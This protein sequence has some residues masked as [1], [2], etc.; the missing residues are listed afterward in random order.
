MLYASD[1]FVNRGEL[2]VI[3]LG[4]Q[5][6]QRRRVT[7]RV[8]SRS[9]AFFKRHT[10]TKRLR[11]DQDI[12]KHDRRIETEAADRL[13]RYLRGEYRIKTEIE[14][15]A[16]LFPN[17][18]VFRK[19]APSLSHQP[20]RRSGVSVVRQRAEQWFSHRIN[21]HAPILLKLT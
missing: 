18:S 19:I 21:S 16:S 7:E 14:K 2:H 20:D 9:L 1:G 17:G 11:H 10:L 6:L 13:Q 5:S 15:T 4:T 12:G 8:E 3:D